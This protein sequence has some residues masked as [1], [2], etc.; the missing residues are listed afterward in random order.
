MGFTDF[1]NAKGGNYKLLSSSPYAQL[2]IPD[3]TALG[4]DISMLSKNIEGVQ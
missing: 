1:K 4:A 3:Q 2:A